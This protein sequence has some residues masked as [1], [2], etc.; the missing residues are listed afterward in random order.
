MKPHLGV[1]SKSKLIRTFAA[2]AENMHDAMMLGK[3]LHGA[4]RQVYGD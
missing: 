4:E 1:D 3:L 2:T